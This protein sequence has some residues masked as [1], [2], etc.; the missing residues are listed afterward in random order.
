MKKLWP[1][2]MLVFFVSGCLG[3]NYAGDATEFAGDLG[4]EG[5]DLALDKLNETLTDAERALVLCKALCMNTTLDLEESPCLSNEV[6]EDWVCDVAHDPREDIDN[7]PE[8]QCEAYREG[9]ADHFVELD[10]ECNLIKI[11]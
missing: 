3:S 10:P 9:E 7:E 5:L 2:L 1:L 11:R 8:N 6:I 4:K